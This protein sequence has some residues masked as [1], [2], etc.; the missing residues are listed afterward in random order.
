MKTVLL[1]GGIALVSWAGSL[2]TAKQPEA[3]S[4]E[5]VYISEGCIH[6]HSQFSRPESLDT[7]IY[8]PATLPDSQMGGAVL[9]G[10]RRQGPDLSS[11]GL[12]RSRQWNREHLIDPG[13]V[14]PRTRMPSYKHLFEGDA[15]KGEALLDYLAGL[16]GT[17]AQDWFAHVSSWKS[18][19]L[20]G[21]A[22]RGGQLF[23]ENCQQC[24]G[25]EG[26]GD[27]VL[28]DRFDPRPT[29]FAAGGFRFAPVS[30]P[31]EVRAQQLARIVKFGISGTAMPGHEYLTD[32]DIADLVSFVSDFSVPSDA[33]K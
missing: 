10:N 12:R 18:S 25:Q 31:G 9:I 8:G 33:A 19:V 20:T 16:G 21:S 27:G 11:I 29:N 5:D 4:G 32:Q 28:S 15:T 17:G 1:I 14:S 22:I 23:A 3:V 6:C 2:F 24:H 30:L 13:L 7:E 26:K